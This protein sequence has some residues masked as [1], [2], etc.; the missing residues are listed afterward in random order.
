MKSKKS[1][2]ISKHQINIIIL[3]SQIVL[4]ILIE[5]SLKIKKIMI[6][7]KIR[8][9]LD[10]LGKNIQLKDLYFKINLKI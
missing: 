7:N 5:I 2:E 6:L 9:K 4:Y 3:S 1:I 8:N 10:K